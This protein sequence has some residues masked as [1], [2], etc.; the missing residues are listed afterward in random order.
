MRSFL[1]VVVTRQNCFSVAEI[2]FVLWRM[3]K[4]P[5]VSVKRPRGSSNETCCCAFGAAA[6]QWGGPHGRVRRP[7]CADQNRP[8]PPARFEIPGPRDQNGS[9]RTGI[10]ACHASIGSGRCRYDNMIPMIDIPRPPTASSQPHR[11]VRLPAEYPRLHQS[12]EIAC[13]KRAGKPS[14]IRFG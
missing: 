2:G 6:A 10:E 3:T 1:A 13:R 8:V 4:Q 14:K 12:E 9:Q 5:H 7:V 11:E